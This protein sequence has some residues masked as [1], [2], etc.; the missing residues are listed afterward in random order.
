MPPAGL[1]SEAEL[2][3]AGAIP[4][5]RRLDV[6]G[7]IPHPRRLDVDCELECDWAAFNCEE[8]PACKTCASCG[9]EPVAAAAGPE[10]VAAASGPVAATN[11]ALWSA[12]GGRKE[13]SSRDGGTLLAFAVHRAV[14]VVVVARLAHASGRGYGLRLQRRLARERTRGAAD[15]PALRLVAA[16]SARLAALV[17]GRR[18]LAC[19]AP[20]HKLRGGRC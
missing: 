13:G 17:G 12:E 3:T 10:P 11:Q 5:R 8:K 18:K 6:A 7:A 16:G 2:M 20:P 19:R 15:V 14:G 9:D 1:A 4:H